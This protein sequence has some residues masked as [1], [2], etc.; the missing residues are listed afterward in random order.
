MR[1]TDPTALAASLPGDTPEE[2]YAVL[3]DAA[4]CPR[5]PIDELSDSVR[6]LPADPAARRAD[7]DFLRE[8]PAGAGIGLPHPVA[9][10]L[11]SRI[12]HAPPAPTQAHE[13]DEPE[14]AASGPRMLPSASRLGRDGDQELWAASPPGVWYD[15][16]LL[17][18]G[19]V[20]PGTGGP[21]AVSS[22][23]WF[24]ARDGR[25]VVPHDLR[26]NRHLRALLERGPQ[27][28]LLVVLSVVAPTG[29]DRHALNEGARRLLV[30][31]CLLPVVCPTRVAARGTDIAQG[32]TPPW[33]THLGFVLLPRRAQIALAAAWRV[34]QWLEDAHWDPARPSARSAIWRP[35][36]DGARK[37]TRLL[38]LFDVPTPSG[39]TPPTD[40]L[41]RLLR[42]ILFVE[43][44]R[45]SRE[46]FGARAILNR[47]RAAPALAALDG[48]AS[49]ADLVTAST[50]LAEA[51]FDCPRPDAGDRYDDLHGVLGDRLKNAASAA[52][53]TQAEEQIC[54]EL[55]RRF[56]PWDDAPGA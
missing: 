42:Q 36:S 39:S 3:L 53:M 7:T 30:A 40:A 13:H 32:A 56:G 4:T 41:A 15:R 25:W 52:G 24:V 21:E 19:L 6:A 11:V 31:R 29:D 1:Y 44:A 8:A 18:G 47:L 16:A 37:L 35:A 48:P 17:G 12:V 27:K 22:R 43:L 28:L 46:S 33:A 23:R 51:F 49:H 34:T 50:W 9:R 45:C 38:R 10:W 14:D 2:V 26:A 54:A 55:K 20:I 5:T